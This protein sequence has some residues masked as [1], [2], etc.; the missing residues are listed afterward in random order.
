MFDAH[1]GR[2][3]RVLLAGLLAVVVVLALVPLNRAEAA[4][5]PPTINGCALT[6]PE[7]DKGIEYWVGSAELEPGTYDLTSLASDHYGYLRIVA[8]DTNVDPVVAL[9]DWRFDFPVQCAGVLDIDC[10]A[11]TFT[12]HSAWSTIRFDYRAGSVTESVGPLGPQESVTIEVPAGEVE[13]HITDF[14]LNTE[15][16]TVL[17]IP[18]CGSPRPTKAPAAGE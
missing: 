4:E 1:A 9:D 16:E 7:A 6:I 11:F 18:S 2:R 5:P 15:F 8:F 3:H 12:D 14:E 10:E 13:V 17:T